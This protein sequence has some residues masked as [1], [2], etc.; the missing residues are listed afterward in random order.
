MTSL[1]TACILNPMTSHPRQL[2]L[3]AP[4]RRAGHWL[5]VLHRLWDH[6]L[7]VRGAQCV[8]QRV[9][10][11]LVCWLT[12]LDTAAQLLAL[13]VPLLHLTTLSTS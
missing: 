4:P 2:R 11:S 6:S 13:R 1:R 5:P 3:Q 9:M 8:V 10:G 7:R 12:R